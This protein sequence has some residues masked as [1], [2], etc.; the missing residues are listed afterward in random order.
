[1]IPAKR[2]VGHDLFEL[3]MKQGRSYHSEHFSLRVVLRSS[4]EKAQFSVVVA[5][6]VDQKAKLAVWRNTLKRHMYKLLRPAISV[7]KPGSLSVFFLKKKVEASK[8]TSLNLEVFTAL[9]KAG[10]IA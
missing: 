1:M 8:L 9:K 5:K 6:K 2:K 10:V 4:Q 7:A 3:L